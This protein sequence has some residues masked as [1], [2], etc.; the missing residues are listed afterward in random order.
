MPKVRLTVQ[1]I[2]GLPIPEKG[3]TDYQDTVV[4]GLILRVSPTGRKTFSVS[5][6]KNGRRP[7]VTLGT[8]ED[9]PKKIVDLPR[10]SLAGARERIHGGH[11]GVNTTPVG[12][13]LLGPTFGSPRCP[14]ILPEPDE[15]GVF[16]GHACK[17][18]L[19]S[20]CIDRV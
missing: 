3:R 12:H 6:W 11:V 9:S 17:M 20:V 10:I 1:E 4:P 18:A 2:K 14:E 8:T 5:W 7:R 19:G 16:L 13:F 15:G